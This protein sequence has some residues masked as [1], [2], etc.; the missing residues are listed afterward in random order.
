MLPLEATAVHR[1]HQPGSTEKHL[2]MKLYPAVEE[3]AWESNFVSFFFLPFFFDNHKFPS[4][5]WNQISVL[6]KWKVS[7]E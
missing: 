5:P 6:T 7:K 4:L 3:K 1:G 2:E